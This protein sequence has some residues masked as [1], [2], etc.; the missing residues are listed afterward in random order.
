MEYVTVALAVSI[1]VVLVLLYSCNTEE[2]K[3]N[4]P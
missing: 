3:K 4:A 2:K 1:V